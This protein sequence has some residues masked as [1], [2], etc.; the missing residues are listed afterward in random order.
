MNHFIEEQLKMNKGK[1]ESCALSLT[2]D[3][4]AAKD[5]FQETVFRVWLNKE[6]FQPGTNFQAWS[7]T[8]MAN[9]FKSS[10]RTK[11]RRREL[12]SNDGALNYLYHQNG[13]D[14]NHGEWLV[15]TYEVEECLD[16]LD[17]KYRIP[18]KL[19]YEGYPYE[20]ITKLM[21]LPLNTLKSRIH[22]GRKKMNQ[23]MK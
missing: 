22:N 19:Q 7:I 4:E 23:L 6:K 1:M 5:L 17:D 10:Y 16:R 9:L 21:K 11:R 13:R 18:L 8:I 14:Y 2:K 20:E 15:F 12:L 3:P